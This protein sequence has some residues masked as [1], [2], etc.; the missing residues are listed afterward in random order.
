[1]FVEI[2]DEGAGFEPSAASGESTGLG[3][4][5]M[6]ERAVLLRGRLTISSAP[7]RGTRIVAELPVR[8]QGDDRDATLSTSEVLPG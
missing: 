1:M 3:L 4:I 8:T 2:E 5:G 7:D 6:R